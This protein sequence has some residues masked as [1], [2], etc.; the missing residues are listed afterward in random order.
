MSTHSKNPRRKRATDNPDHARRTH[1]AAPA[2][3]EIEARLTALVQPAVYAELDHYRQLGLRNRLLT[4]PV[5]VSLVLTLIWRRVAGVC[6]LTRLLARERVLWSQPMRVAQPSLSERFLT[7]PAELFHAILMRVL[8]AL[9]PRASQRTRPVPPVF[10]RLAGRFTAYY[11]LDGT[12]LEALFRKL[13]AL[14]EAP[15]APLAGHLVAAINLVTQLP[16]QLWWADDPA[17][18]DKALLPAVKAWLT[19]GSLLVFDLGYF[20]FPLFD[21]LT[22]LKV[23]F[24]TR[25]RAKTSYQVERVL[26]AG[27]HLRDQIVQLGVYR[28][29]PSRHAVRLIEVYV[30][31]GWRQYVTNVLDPQVLSV[32]DGVELYDRRWHIETAFLLVKRLLDL[33]YLWVGSLNGVPLQV[34]A[35][36]LFYAV[37][38]DLCD[39]VAEALAQPLE[40]ISVEMVYRGLYHYVTAVAQG[41]EGDVPTYYAQPA[42]R[43]LGIVKRRRARD[44]PSPVAQLRIALDHPV[45]PPPAPT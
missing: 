36:W 16:T 10:R 45:G 32:I 40:A 3:S 22:D 18:N 26:R 15:D 34:W 20:A 24:V 6:E 33:A 30:N 21:D 25:L 44:G 17:T 41:F 37:L 42:H 27:P 28:S 29:N 4:L 7:F 35:T 11:A 8:A 9:P 13:A 31:D 1:V 5:M 12:T 19:A 14:R 2:D 38:I 39:D 43:D 23:S